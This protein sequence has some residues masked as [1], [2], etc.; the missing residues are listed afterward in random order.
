MLVGLELYIGGVLLL[1]GAAFTLLAAIGVVRLPDLYTRMHAASKAGAVGGGLIL[2]A[3]AV[4]SQD[5]SVSMRAV[6]GV[7]F[8]L[9]TTPVS[10]H[11]LARA[12]YLSGYKPC[13][14]TLIDELASNN[15]Q[16]PAT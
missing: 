11:L 10:A 7:V 2:I 8:L 14:Q 13:S 15:E 5:A 16:N 1:L 4:L 3:V 9:L 6:I 12:S